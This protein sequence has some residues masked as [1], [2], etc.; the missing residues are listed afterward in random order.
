M[1]GVRWEIFVVLLEL[2]IVAG[3]LVV[4]MG[5]RTLLGSFGTRGDTRDHVSIIIISCYQACHT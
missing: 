3:P 1:G 2:E 5:P 4:W